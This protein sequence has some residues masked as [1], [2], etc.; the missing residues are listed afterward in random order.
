MSEATNRGDYKA[1]KAK[2]NLPARHRQHEGSNQGQNLAKGPRLSIQPDTQPLEAAN[3]GLNVL[4]S[5]NSIVDQRIDLLLRTLNETFPVTSRPREREALTGGRTSSRTKRRERPRKVTRKITGITSSVQ[6]TVAAAEY[7]GCD[8]SKARRHLALS[9]QLYDSHHLEKSRKEA[10][11]AARQASNS[12]SS[13]LPDAVKAV[14]ESIHHL[15]KFGLDLSQEKPL[16]Y[17][18]IRAFKKKEYRKAV[19][20]LAECKKRLR[21]AELRPALKALFKAR[22]GVVAARKAGC[23]V[24]TA[25]ALLNQSMMHLKAGNAAEAEAC[26]KRCLAAAEEPM[27]LQR[28]SHELIRACARSI[29]IAR[30]LGTNV[31]EARELVS[32]SQKLLSTGNFVLATECA[33]KAIAVSTVNT[34]NQISGLID[35]ATKNLKLAKDADIPAEAAESSLEKAKK[36]L[37]KKEFANSLEMAYASLFDSNAAIVGDLQ[38][39]VKRFD[40]FA[41]EMGTEIDSFMQVQDAIEHSK[42]RSLET[43]RKYATLS[44]EIVS[45]AYENATA[46]ARV[47]QDIMGQA[48]ESTVGLAGD[49]TPAEN[50]N[51]SMRMY[52][53]VLGQVMA[54]SNGDRRLRII[55]T[56]L[57]G[58]I[59]A[60]ELDKLLEL[61]DSNP[62]KLEIVP[63]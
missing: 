28:Q 20:G 55:D 49:R 45:Q 38:K 32:Q 54:I 43:I 62:G 63:P 51:A 26:A 11:V 4:R 31:D 37:S 53:S 13:V 22:S 14:S 52:S 35:L 56:F 2:Q 24:G 41:K 61:M 30:G 10:I 42:E 8:M 3:D 60:S 17:S 50:E 29:A 39:R 33:K 16:L 27:E 12:I 19:L 9:T 40:Q 5:R 36:F 48:C 25:T 7:L 6:E 47:S 59:S 57:S 21:E 58:K 23:D 18:S 15:E 34:S 1:S 44:E 46:Y